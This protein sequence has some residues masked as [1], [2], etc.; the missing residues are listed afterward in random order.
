MVNELFNP[1][2]SVYVYEDEKLEMEMNKCLGI[3]K[4]GLTGSFFT[5]SVENKKLYL[6][7]LHNYV[8]NFYINEKTTGSEVG[9]QPFGGRL[10]SG[11]NDKCGGDT[12]IYK[13]CNQMS[14]KHRKSI[15]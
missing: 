15:S 11:T 5:S 4:Y 14:V 2:L 7:K 10:K 6:D 3:S 1:I 8:G 9:K 13:L 12:F